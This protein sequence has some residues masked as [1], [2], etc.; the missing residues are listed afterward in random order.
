MEDI[1]SKQRENHSENK[2]L[3]KAKHK[4]VSDIREYDVI[5]DSE[6]EKCVGIKPKVTV[7]NNLPQC[8][9]QK[10]DEGI[11]AS[12]NML[13]NSG[14]KH[15]ESTQISSRNRLS[16]ADKNCHGLDQTPALRCPQVNTK[17]KI[18]SI[19]YSI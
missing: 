13:R 5:S 8:P 16:S 6:V 4:I 11:E 3:V 19:L 1:D 15:K 2:H 18:V 17:E 10:N 14:T 12:G 7:N 9:G